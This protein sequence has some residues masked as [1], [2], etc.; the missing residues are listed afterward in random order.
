MSFDKERET[1]DILKDPRLDILRD[2][3]GKLALTATQASAVLERG[4]LL[5]SAAAGSG[6][7]STLVKR[8]LITVA[9]GTAT[10]RDMLVCVYNDSAQA[11]LKQRLS[12]SFIDAA[13]RETDA[14]RRQR[15]LKAVDDLPFCRISTIHAF[16][17]S[18][19][20]ENF[21]KLGISPTYEIADDAQ[22]GEL[23]RAAV[24][25]VIDEFAEKGDEKL[26]ALIDAFSQHRNESG[27]SKTILD[28]CERMILQEDRQQF[29]LRLCA[30]FD[31]SPLHERLADLFRR[32][33]RQALEILLP[34]RDSV[35]MSEAVR[36][37]LIDVPMDQAVELANSIEGADSF[38]TMCKI[39]AEA[40]P[41]A[42]Y[43]NK[44]KY[45]GLSGEETDLFY[46]AKS[47]IND[48]NDVKATLKDVYDKKEDFRRY[49]AQN[50]EYIGKLVELAERTLEVLGELKAEKN[51]LGYDDLLLLAKRLLNENND[52][53][54]EYKIVFVDEYQ[55]V[56]PLQ[57]AIFSK[58]IKDECF[59][60]GDVK[61]SIYGFRLADPTILLGRR[62]A[63]EAGEGKNI[64]FTSNFRSNREILSFVNEVFDAVMT[65][66]SA[67]VDYKRD[68]AFTVP[69]AE[70]KDD[71]VVLDGDGT[72][73]RE[74]ESMQKHV[75]LCFVPFISPEKSED[76]EKPSVP[77]GLY[78]I[79]SAETDDGGA[80]E[81]SKSDRL[82]TF[83]LNEI[84]S[85]VGHALRE[86]CDDGRKLSYGD[87]AILAR[88]NAA[89]DPKLRHVLKVLREAGI[90]L[91]ETNVG[92]ETSDV[93]KELIVM[94]RVIDNPRQDIPLAGYLLSY[95]GGY[96]EQELADIASNRGECFYDK[97]LAQSAK[98]G[99]LANKLRATLATLDDYRLK[100]SF[101]NVRELLQSIISDYMYDAHVKSLGEGKIAE[102]KNFV[103][104][105]DEVSIGKFLEGYASVQ[106]KAVGA[107]TDS[108]K[109]STIHKYKGL[110]SPVVFVLDIA[111][112]LRERTDEPM[113]S[114]YGDIGLKYYDGE[115]KVAYETF[116]RFAL[117]KLM[118]AEQVKDEMRL[119]YVAFTRAKQLLYV[120]ACVKKDYDSKEFGKKPCLGGITNT[121]D[122]LSVARLKQSLLR[123]PEVIPV[124]VRDAPAAHAPVMNFTADEELKAELLRAREQKYADEEATKLAMKYTV[125]QIGSLE[126]DGEM[127]FEESDKE[128]AKIGTAY[129]K[130]MQF[131]DLTVDTQE[132]VASEL[133]AMR[134][135]GKLSEEERGYIDE[136]L[137]LACLGSPVMRRAAE[138][139]SR[140]DTEREKPFTMLKPAR[141]L[142]IGEGK[143]EVLV[144][145]VIDLYIKDDDGA[146]VDFK[147]GYVTAKKVPE[148][149]KKQLYLYKMAVEAATKGKVKD[150]YIY[151]FASGQTVR[152]DFD[153]EF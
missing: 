148:H 65:S 76:D 122:L 2:A 34:V 23:S 55:D 124:P 129:H 144:Q 106:T 97:L 99:E 17:S 3:N 110:E 84:N 70:N 83:I 31:H 95:F 21:E 66:D 35:K 94:L 115:K 80:S 147:T 74:G 1:E 127:L 52:I 81:L 26:F 109:V 112:A 51:V 126:D 15:L 88:R 75:R 135:E 16:C 151:S 9:E 53:G 38:M 116:S 68:G 145:G 59:M 100:A 37:K 103:A 61:Q 69:E 141:E 77:K 47:C 152:L 111:S 64:D 45:D 78:D 86:D 89:N 150:V 93:E 139:Y 39:A 56:D 67:D 73:N 42:T 101:K 19:I 113:I 140:G 108:V 5:V 137:V 132:G 7:T 82:A 48:M 27:L 136:K 18:L 14:V 134:E 87:I 120:T 33:M 102:L 131:I 121:I 138:A 46:L 118:Q 10:L 92:G 49:H 79:M 125:S 36:G 119:M 90:P 32:R 57:E 28:I 8:I 117:K 30:D 105:V 50:V 58:L 62:A 54:E 63:Y 43:K 130:V 22:M 142:G 123:Q 13:M 11:E 85:L 6:K 146:I 60:V 41:F 107:G 4:R 143:D 133:D 29:K 114:N 96:T 98:E 153:G 71:K 20:R 72:E 91:D 40:A 149:Y 44:N 25:A 24:E 104:S 12:A 128:A